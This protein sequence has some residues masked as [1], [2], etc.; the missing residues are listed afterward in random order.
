MGKYGKP[1]ASLVKQKRRNLL[2]RRGPRR[3]CYKPQIHWRKLRVQSIVAFHWLSCDNLSLAEMLPSKE[4]IFLPPDG[5][6]K[7]VSFPAGDVRSSPV[8]I[9]IDIEW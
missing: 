6:S 3:G 2:R 8:G 9:C 4:K 5:S 7:V 1:H